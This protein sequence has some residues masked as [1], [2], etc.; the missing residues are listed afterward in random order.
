M[1]YTVTEAYEQKVPKD[2]QQK[3]CSKMQKN[4]A[5]IFYATVVLY[6]GFLEKLVVLKMGGVYRS[7]L[8][9]IVH[10][11][12]LQFEMQARHR[13]GRLEVKWNATLLGSIKMIPTTPLDSRK[14]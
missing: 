12:S 10:W 8:I 11:N 4:F 2:L 3:F 14:K 5:F 7:N 6:L 9:Y 13:E 1:R